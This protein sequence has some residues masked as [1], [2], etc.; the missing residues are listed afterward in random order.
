MKMR[1]GLIAYGLDRPLSGIS[2]YTLE[3]IDA[4]SVPATELELTLLAA[5][6]LGPLEAVR[7]RRY[8]LRGCGLLPALVTW[9]SILIPR[10][11]RQEQLQLVHDPTGVCPL[12]GDTGGAKKIVT[13]HDVYP[14]SFPGTSTRIENWIYRFWLPRV[15]PRVNAVLT[16]SQTSKK[17]IVRYLSVPEKKIHVI[18]LGVSAR[19]RPASS[20]QVE[21]MRQK[22][23]LPCGYVLAIG[24][25][26]PRKNFSRLRDAYQQLVRAGETRPLVVIGKGTRRM[27]GEDA[28]VI[29]T[30]YVP[31]ED[32]PAL[33]SGADVFVFPSL[34][35]GFGLPPLEAMACGAA[36]V[37]SNAASLAEV[38]G[39]AALP[40]DA[41][42]I[43]TLADGMARVLR[44]KNLGAGL[45]ERGLKRA[46]QFTWERTAQ[47]TLHVY[48]Q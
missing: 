14:L 43:D 30:G 38:V 13:L 42:N 29:Y 4:L 32:L 24:S 47:A 45:R 9:G 37:C 2:R 21:A 7:L 5:G 17:D 8:P 6:R 12:W 39:D 20:S 25:R 11:V 31:D 15:L 34:Y 40:V 1:G 48:R 18:P 33:Y 28:S 22:Y 41:A 44:D 23:G 10:A 27:A 46:A 16:D 35:E 19:Y 36:V 3:L 26:N